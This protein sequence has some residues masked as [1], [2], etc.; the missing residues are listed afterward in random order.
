MLCLHKNEV[1]KVFKFQ[2]RLWLCRVWSC[3]GRSIPAWAPWL[4]IDL[5]DDIVSFLSVLETIVLNIKRWN[6]GRTS[7]GVNNVTLSKL[8]ELFPVICS[9]YST[10]KWSKQMWRKTD[11]GQWNQG[12]QIP[13]QWWIAVT[14]F[15]IDRLVL[16]WQIAKQKYYEN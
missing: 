13:L 14:L 3:P 8:E 10:Q 15:I 5:N 2:N 6:W 9:N 1:F 4:N 11:L 7:F 12:W 16:I